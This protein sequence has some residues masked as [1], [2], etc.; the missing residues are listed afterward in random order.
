MVRKDPK[1]ELRFVSNDCHQHGHSDILTLLW[2]KAELYQPNVA[3]PTDLFKTTDRMSMIRSGWGPGQTYLYFNGDIF[4]SS[5]NEV[6]LTTGGLAWHYKWHG[7]QRAESGVETE[8][9][10][11]APSML[12]T[13][14][15]H[16]DAFSFIHTTSSTSNITYYMPPG[17]SDCYKHYTQRDRDILYVRGNQLSVIGNRSSVIGADRS[18]MTDDRSP[19]DPGYFL[20]ID[21]VAQRDPRW[22]AQ[23]WQTWNNVYE[24]KAENFGRYKIESP[25]LVRVERPNADLALNFLSPAVR[26]EVEGT[27]AQPIVSYMYDHNG[28]TLRAMAAEPNLKSETLKSEIPPS[29][30]RGAGK[31]VRDDL[32]PDSPAEAYQL[33]GKDAMVGPKGE[34]LSTLESPVSLQGGQR[35]RMAIRF[36]KRDMGVYENQCWQINCELLDDAS[37]VIAASHGENHP[38]PLTLWDPRSMTRTTPWLSTDPAYFDVPAGAKVA[39]IRGRLVAALWL[40]P[41]HGITPKSILELGP[42]TIESVGAVHRAMAET[43]ATLATPL[44]KGAAAPAVVC[45]TV[46]G[47][48]Y[49]RLTRPD[50][51]VDHIVVGDGKQIDCELGQVAAEV[52]VIRT[53]D[54]NRVESVFARGATLLRWNGPPLLVSPTPVDVSIRAKDGKTTW[55]RIA[56]AAPVQLTLMGT[57][58]RLEKGAFLAGADLKFS[59]DPAAAALATNSPENQKLLKAGLAP[60]IKQIESERDQLTAK[61]MENLVL[62]AKVTASAQRDPRFAPEKVIDN[63][64]WE[65]PADGLLD[66]TQ[67]ELLTTPGGG[68]GT[69]RASLTADMSS[70]PFYIRP[71]YWLLPYQAAGW[72]Q[73]E[74]KNES[75]VS[76]V[77]LL[78]TSNAGANDYATMKFRVELLDSAGKVL[79]GQ[80][81]EFGQ[82]F[83]RPF[84]QAFKAPQIFSKFGETFKGMLEP[85]IK[86]SFGDGWQT[87]EFKGSPKAK[88]VKVYIDSW[89]RWAAGSTRFR[90]TDYRKDPLRRRHTF[91]RRHGGR[92]QCSATG[93]VLRRMGVAARS[94]CPPMARPRGGRGC[95][96]GGVSVPRCTANLAG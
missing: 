59:P 39:K 66:Y 7:Y 19:A 20:Y 10:G 15:S 49:A 96:A 42:L 89:W 16:D 36:R 69:G 65:Y 27:P 84:Q 58:I 41:P 1:G 45:R 53:R 74:L 32:G 37:A 94:L 9:E 79:A 61:G 48:T 17:Q 5:L 46:D 57:P 90:C 28:L 70:W 86:V 52:A 23:L 87:I 3:G 85:G 78:N 30:W 73:L 80:K 76:V 31:L 18:P 47:Q 21:R 14:S 33:V 67:G 24:N 55:A 92:G 56:T 83:D 13:Q 60:L 2:T 93:T 71:T 4:L 75:P 35:Y 63:A 82:L 62:T 8:G 38:D 11:L 6:L 68:Y 91:E 22:H 88:F 95:R 34:S 44:T 43:F 29:S 64:T 26:F 72:I 54:A 50:G 25:S 12:I 81:G 77:R 40:H 51:G